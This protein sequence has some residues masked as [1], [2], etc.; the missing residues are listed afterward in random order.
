MN[1]ATKTNFATTHP[2]AV[3]DPYD[4][5]GQ[6]KVLIT[7]DGLEVYRHDEVTG[8]LIFQLSGLNQKDRDWFEALNKLGYEGLD[9]AGR[10]SLCDKISAILFQHDIL[11]VLMDRVKAIG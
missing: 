9:D 11:A 1:K 8:K 5:N 10:E 4:N 7:I 6:P 2:G 3:P